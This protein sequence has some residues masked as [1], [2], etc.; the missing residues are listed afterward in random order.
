MPTLKKLTATT[1]L[2]VLCLGA[3]AAAEDQAFPYVDDLTNPDAALSPGKDQ[4]T[5]YEELTSPF[6]HAVTLEG[7][8]GIAY[9]SQNGRFVLRGV[10]FDS[11]TGET[12]QTMD[13]LRAAKKSVNIA[14]LG[15]KEEDV[16]PFHWGSGPKKITVFVDPLCPFCGQLFDQLLSDPGYARDYTFTIYTVPFL[17]DA[18]SKAVTVLSCAKNR[19]EAVQALLTKDQ[20]WMQTQAAPE[21]CDPQPIIQRT[22]LSQMLGITGVP[23]LIGAEGG[24]ARGLPADLRSFLETS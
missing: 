10:I 5:S 24:V 17:G 8:D 20:R 19:D 2:A 3:A 16:D 1:L 6:T 23:Y 12:I 7:R 14:D 4:I 18:S 13:A 11:W 21:N 15:L 22:I 9:I